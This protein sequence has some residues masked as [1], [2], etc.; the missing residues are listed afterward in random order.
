[1]KSVFL[2]TALFK[3]N[4]DGTFRK[5]KVGCYASKKSLENAK[6]KIKK[7]LLDRDYANYIWDEFFY[8]KGV[9]KNMES[10]WNQ[11]INRTDYSVYEKWSHK[12]GHPFLNFKEFL[13]EKVD[14]I[15]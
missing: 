3:D 11:N 6:V 13:I 15:D 5:I 8:E 7:D 4:F 12:I 9:N 10:I 14:V 1:M 2:L